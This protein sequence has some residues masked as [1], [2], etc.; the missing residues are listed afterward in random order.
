MRERTSERWIILC[1]AATGEEA[2]QICP[3]PKPVGGGGVGSGRTPRERYC[4]LDDRVRHNAHSLALQPF[5]NGGKETTWISPNRL[6][7][8][9]DADFSFLRVCICSVSFSPPLRWRYHGSEPNFRPCGSDYSRFERTRVSPSP[10]RPRLLGVGSTGLTFCLVS[11]SSPLLYAASCTSLPETEDGSYLDWNEWHHILLPVLPVTLRATS[12]LI[13]HC[14]KLA[15]CHSGQVGP[16]RDE[17]NLCA[18]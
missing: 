10:R 14:Q 3:E 5:I 8:R 13:F 15:A 12:D 11:A 1:L 16:S 7:P 9:R 2:W 4:C 18:A 17:K 6:S